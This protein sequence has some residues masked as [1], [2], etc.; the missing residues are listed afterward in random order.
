MAA[1]VG[2]DR[3]V[4]DV[5]AFVDAGGAEARV[6]VLE[7]EP[8][9]GKTTLWRAGVEAARERGRLVLSCEASG[10][11][12]QLALT[13]FRDLLGDAFE[14]IADELPDP[15]RNALNVALLRTDPSGQGPDAGAVA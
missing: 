13:V 5:A 10:A 7:G 15:Q 3:E 12:T 4:E 14:G 9:I 1:V 8:G 2:R 6:L 11:E